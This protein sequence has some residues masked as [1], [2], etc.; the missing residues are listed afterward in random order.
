MRDGLDVYAPRGLAEPTRQDGT[1]RLVQT[2]EGLDGD[3]GKAKREYE[4]ATYKLAEKEMS[5]PFIA[6]AP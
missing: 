3:K 4:P 5:T 2:H 1:R 6:K